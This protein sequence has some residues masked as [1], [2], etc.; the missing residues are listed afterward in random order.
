MSDAS[1][2]ALSPEE[3]FDRYANAFEQREEQMKALHA[4]L[5]RDRDVMRVLYLTY[6]D[7]GKAL[8][9]DRTTEDAIAQARRHGWIAGARPAL[10]RDGLYVWWHWKEKIAPYARDPWFQSLWREVMSW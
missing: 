7:L 4:E 2:S 9:N 5:S 1:P 6:L 3:A 8:I 10:T